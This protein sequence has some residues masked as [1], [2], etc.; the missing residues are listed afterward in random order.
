MRI[1]I[2]RTDKG[3]FVK[4]VSKVDNIECLVIR[5][6]YIGLPL[7][8]MNRA[9]C[10]FRCFISFEEL[11]ENQ[12]CKIKK[13]WL[14][15]DNYSVYKEVVEETAMKVIEIVNQ[16]IIFQSDNGKYLFNE[17]KKFPLFSGD[18]FYTFKKLDYSEID[19][20]KN[21]LVEW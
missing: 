4:E 12:M 8:F 13:L 17:F 9:S 7:R 10:F 11:N 6:I 14:M 18:E 16:N 1:Y 3:K 2:Y 15:Q 21:I 5:T 20:L 19:R